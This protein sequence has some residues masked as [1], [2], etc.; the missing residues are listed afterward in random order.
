[1]Y[2]NEKPAGKM[3]VSFLAPKFPTP[4]GLSF[5][6]T[7]NRMGKEGWEVVGL[8]SQAPDV[9][10]IIVVLKHQLSS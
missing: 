6:D 7:L 3:K 4:E 1:M 5:H 10:G 8:A 2:V 9:F